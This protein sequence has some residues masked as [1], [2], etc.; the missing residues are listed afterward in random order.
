MQLYCKVM[1][2]KMTSWCV[3][4]PFSTLAGKDIVGSGLS[5]R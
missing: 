2:I 1:L 3:K 4:A 5:P